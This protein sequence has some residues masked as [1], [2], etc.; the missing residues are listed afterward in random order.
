MIKENIVEKVDLPEGISVEISG[1]TVKL[2]G[3][4]NE[5]NRTFKVKGISFK[6]MDRS[7]EIEAIPATKK[8]N[9]R[10]RTVIGHLKNMAAGLDKEFEYKLAIVYSHFP[11]SVNV[12]GEVIEINNFAGEKNPRKAKVLPGVTIEIKGKDVFVRGHNKENVGQT[13]A[14]LEKATR[15][16]GRDKR[17][18]QDGIFIVSKAK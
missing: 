1:N 14:N 2:S 7:I 4:G 5:N 3:K 8:M 10:L 12:K 13:A 15:V 9:A 16:K 11:M 6:K 18:F 17:I